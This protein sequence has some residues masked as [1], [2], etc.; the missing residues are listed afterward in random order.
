MSSRRRNSHESQLAELLYRSVASLFTRKIKQAQ[1][2]TT[3]SPFPSLCVERLE[4]RDLFA[5]AV[6]GNDRILRVTGTEAADTIDVRLNQG[7]LSIQDSQIVVNSIAL[8]SVESSAVDQIIVEALGGDDI[9]RL[10]LGGQA[11][12]IPSTIR[13]GLGSDIIHGGTGKDTID[14][15][16]GTDYLYGSD[17]DDALFGGTEDD[18]RDWLNGEY[19]NDQLFGGNRSDILSGQGGNDVLH[20]QG[21]DDYQLLGGAGE[22]EIY[23]EAGNDTLDGG[24]GT[25]YLFGGDD[26]DVIYGGAEDDSRDWLNGE[27]G[28]DKLYGGGGSDIISGQAGNDAIFGEAGDDYQLLGGAGEDTIYGGSGND[29]LDGG[30]GADVLFGGNG[31]DTI[32]GGA[33]DDAIDRLFGDEGNDK[34]Y[35]GAGNDEI[36]GGYGNDQIW[37]D[38]GADLLD[39]KEGD[40]TIFGGKDRDWNISDAE[41]SVGFMDCSATQADVNL[42]NLSGT[43]WVHSNGLPAT[44]KQQGRTLVLTDEY[45]SVL[46]ATLDVD[47]YGI[48]VAHTDHPSPSNQV[49]EIRQVGV[50]T[51]LLWDGN[52]WDR[53]SV[54]GTYFVASNGLKASIR[55]SG[56]TLTLTDEYNTSTEA[57]WISSTRFE[58]WGQEA[59]V[60][61][62]GSVTYI[63]WDGNYWARGSI[64]GDYYVASNGMKA[65]IRQSGNTLTLT[66]E[67]GNDTRTEWESPTQFS[68]WGQSVS[69]VQ[70]G[71]LT[72]ILWDGNSWERGSISGDYFVTSNG[73]KA[74]I[75]QNG[76][77]ISLTDEHGNTTRATWDSATQFHAWGQ[78]ATMT[79][80]GFVTRIAWFGNAWEYS[81]IAYISRDSTG[82]TLEV[83]GTP[84]ADDIKVHSDGSLLWVEMNNQL[85]FRCLDNQLTALAIN[86]G[87]GNDTITLQLTS[88]VAATVFGADGNDFLI[89]SV[90]DDVLLGGNG[91]DWVFGESGNDVLF[92]ENGN[93]VLMGGL[94]DDWLFAGL[95][96]SDQLDSDYHQT[97]GNDTYVVAGTNSF[98]EVDEFRLVTRNDG[99]IVTVREDN[100][101]TDV[102]YY[103]DG[104]TDKMDDDL[105]IDRTLDNI[106]RE[107]SKI[108]PAVVD[109]VTGLFSEGSPSSS[110]PTSASVTRGFWAYGDSVASITYE[111]GSSWG[112]NGDSWK[113]PSLYGWH[114]GSYGGSAFENMMRKVDPIRPLRRLWD[115][116]VSAA[117]A[118]SDELAITYV[119]QSLAWSGGRRSEEYFDHFLT[120]K[121]AGA[122]LDVAAYLEDPAIWKKLSL[123]MQE[124]PSGGFLDIDLDD[125]ASP[126]WKLSVGRAR[127]SWDAWQEGAWTEDW[128]R[129]TKITVKSNYLSTE[130]GP[131]ISRMMQRLITN[132]KATDFQITGTAILLEDLGFEKR[133]GGK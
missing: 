8:G 125:Y 104:S 20:G 49:I 63:L 119:R 72:R 23:G 111:G 68:A 18:S 55:Q 56:D 78:V 64:A 28:N 60:V 54:A 89:G 100:K 87:A 126:D 44:I 82:A 133:F 124:S 123:A 93:D 127:V 75:S 118:T 42:P 12:S 39:G 106:I 1:R 117:S 5:V 105:W 9:V 14:G 77:V 74:S 38:L 62:Q 17:G 61:Q 130:R 4:S 7:R 101:G 57:H 16:A 81:S 69:V 108:V 84:D 96:G 94:G 46:H 98:S 83:L 71:Y 30:S 21:G 32:Y 58:A 51:Q 29:T 85:A 13:G 73:L 122:D 15:G 120:G 65:S 76:E 47:A 91:D 53:S 43:W 36:E 121:G 116:I 131:V 31:H 88:S 10:D 129:K 25:D 79:Q 102:L 95:E 103:N 86:A 19:G 6:L 27:Y 114:N 59:S 99:A 132:G 90:H 80:E 11:L 24:A 37:G 109:F 115:E 97:H 66:D 3:R 40:D 34:L 50:K 128:V 35:G 22:D 113:Q 92:G 107:L 48:V 45:G 112:G 52:T 33:E 41:D 26:H 110:S 2:R 67:Y 70:E